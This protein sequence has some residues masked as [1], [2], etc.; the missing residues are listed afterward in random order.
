MAVLKEARLRERVAIGK[1]GART[2]T[3]F[4]AITEDFDSERDRWQ[5]V[6]ER[7]DWE[8]EVA[9]LEHEGHSQAENNASSSSDSSDSPTSDNDDSDAEEK[10]CSS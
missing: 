10:S 4:G 9:Q 7:M 5:E 8:G 6:E 1:R 3:G 2:T